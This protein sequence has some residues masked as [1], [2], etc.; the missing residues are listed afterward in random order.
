MKVL[1]T[2]AGGYLGGVLAEHLSRQPDIESVT[3]TTQHPPPA[4]RPPKTTWIQRDI[5]DPALAGDMERHQ[6]VIHAACVV[7]WP[8]WMSAAERDSINND[9]ARNAARAARAAGVT[10]FVHASSMAVYD[11]R[12]VRGQT[13]VTED[14]PLGGP[15]PYFYYWSAKAQAERILQENLAGS[16]TRLT[17]LRPIYIMGPRGRATAKRYRENAV[18]F[19]GLDPRRQFVHEDDVAAAFLLALRTD[20]PGAYNVTPDDFMR[21]S[22]VWKALGRRWTPSIPLWLARAAVWAQWRFA[23]GAL[24]PSWV[25]DMLVDFT[26]SNARLRAA[27]WQPRW[28]SAQALAASC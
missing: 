5:R 14:F 1:L 23:G 28:T 3:C 21:M 26:G 16:G 2:G 18:N 24:H 17:L 6:A 4:S 9:G 22:Q 13:G 11:L 8:S 15:D 19:P 12:Q 25:E 20:M 10:R 7:F 27:G